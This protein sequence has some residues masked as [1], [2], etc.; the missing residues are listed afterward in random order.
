MNYRLFETGYGTLII[1]KIDL[2]FVALVIFLQVC[3]LPVLVMPPRWLLQADFYDIEFCG[4]YKM[5]YT[6][7]PDWEK[8]KTILDE[9][10]VQEL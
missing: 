2:V 5:L 3:V 9:E 6:L 10:I 4:G 8:R 7:M 1:S